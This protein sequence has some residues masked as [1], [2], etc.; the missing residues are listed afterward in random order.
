MD[1]SPLLTDEIFTAFL[2]C[3][4][5]AHL[6]LRGITGEKSDYERSH[7]E[8]AASYRTL[9]TEE[10]LRR[11]HGASVIQ[12]PSSLSDALLTG[13]PLIL[14]TTASDAGDSCRI[15]ALERV[16][17]TGT[18]PATAYAPIFFV[19]NEKVS[20]HD[21]L[22]CAFQA[23]ILSRVQGAQPQFGTIVNGKNF[24]QSRVELV[25][26]AGALGNTLGQLKT[27][28]AGEKAPPLVLN[29][30]C[31]ECEFR[32]QCRATAIQKDDLS[33]LTGLSPKEIAEHNRKGIFTITQF[34]YTFRPGRMKRIVEAGGRRHDPALQALALRERTIYITQR[35]AVPNPK[36]K[37]YLD[38]EGL[39]DPTFIYLLGLLIV[40]GDSCQRLSFWA[41][42]P[43]EEAAIW[44][45]FL[46][47]LVGLGEDF[48]LYHYG[49]YDSR[50]LQRMA[51]L[52]GG[53]PELLRRIE[54]RS[55]N[56]L[57]LIHGRV[58]F[59]TYGNDLKSLA[60]YF[61]FSWSIPEPS[62]LQ[63]IAWRY[64]WEATGE[65]TFKQRLLDYNQEDCSALQRVVEAIRSLGADPSS[66]GVSQQVANVDDIKVPRG[67]K[68]CN[69]EYALPEFA[70]ITKCSYFDYQR[71]K[72]LFRTSP[73]VKQANR[74]KEKQRRPACKINQIVE[75]PGPANCPH[76]GSDDFGTQGCYSRL[77]VDLKTVR[78]GLKGWV[79]R[80]KARR[81]LCRQCGGNW[82][83]ED[84]LGG[85][86]LHPGRPYK[87]GWTL[88]GWVAYATVVLRLTN[89][90]IAEALR[91]HFGIIIR[92]AVVSKVRSQAADRY[93]GTYE[94]LLASL[95][96]GQLVH[97]DETWGKVKGASK[98]GYVWAFASPDV[99]VYVYSPTRKGDPVQETLAG[100]KGVLV[101][102]FYA[103]YDAL[104][105]P[106]QKC[107]VHLLRD[108][109][110]DLVKRPF[111]EELKQLAGRFASLMQAIV[112]TIDRYGL[113]KYHLHK[114]KQEVDRFYER[115]S[116]A[117]YAS[118]VARHYRQRFLK[119][120]DKLFTFLDHDG[121]PWN[122]NNAE[123]AVKR[124]VSR[125]KSLGGTGA[126]SESGLRDY[127]LLLS[128]YQTLR[129]RNI[130]FWK[131]LLSGE[132]DIA[133]FTTKCR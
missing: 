40:E 113:K 78:G 74:R 93:R 22:L 19:H 15:D 36:V 109:N 58:F 14:G 17:L 90:A 89:E 46:H 131:F 121:V 21:R 63:A 91:D 92:S 53:D 128:I 67:H 83:A 94:S 54:G 56:V 13:V 130:S 81:Y 111:D 105:C 25:T 41:D 108:L 80:H 47:I 98:R 88:C 82:V 49:S 110:D 104:D 112:Q 29:K 38:A 61:G 115:E 72:V 107:L 122:N 33:L 117:A 11:H 60:G 57:A 76:C 10:L 44:A 126:L 95:R 102:D 101:S 8:R 75:Y 96:K 68:F 64:D 84:Y 39:I 118:E 45:S 9:A 114:H 103:A 50:F 20:S 62:G 28:A 30:H 34:S 52:H 133:A 5:K 2:H 35:Q 125:R 37:V 100:F 24:K 71:T 27:L 43:T 69:P 16:D 106:Q 87:Y 86:A 85:R 31:S 99:A 129:Y 97:A 23:S 7:A 48:V 51:K 127:L 120:R 6:E 1:P 132:T 12:R 119:Y 59:P 32:R 66:D 4:Y 116:A 42:R 65:E 55:V 26:L 79:T 73:A 3:R 77:I 124:F 18:I 123:N 70:G